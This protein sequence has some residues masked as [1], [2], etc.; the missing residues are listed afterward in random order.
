[1]SMLPEVYTSLSMARRKLGSCAGFFS[2]PSE[3]SLALSVA[4]LALS[5]RRWLSCSKALVCI[6]ASRADRSASLSWGR[7]RFPC[8][9]LDALAASAAAFTLAR[10]AAEGP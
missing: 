2:G 8:P 7:G 5:S 1:M 4:C 6:S 3:A 10:C 9:G